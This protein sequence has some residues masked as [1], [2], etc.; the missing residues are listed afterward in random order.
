MAELRNIITVERRNMTR[1]SSSAGIVLY[2]LLALVGCGGGGSA[3]GTAGSNP[4]PPSASP[5]PEPPPPDQ[6]V[7][8]GRYLGTVTIDGVNYFGDA[9]L[10]AN[11]ETHNS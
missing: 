1:T 8:H 4:P 9:L 5:P 11:G 2:S 7:D 3:P 10:A 6:S